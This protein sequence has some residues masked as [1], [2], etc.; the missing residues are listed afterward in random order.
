MSQMVMGELF[1]AD[2]TWE[3]LSVEVV[4]GCPGLILTTPL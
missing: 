4:F 3:G 2:V 1:P